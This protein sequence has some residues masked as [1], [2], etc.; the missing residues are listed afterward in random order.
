[1][2]CG[3]EKWNKKSQNTRRHEGFTVSPGISEAWHLLQTLPKKLSLFRSV[4]NFHV[5]LCLQ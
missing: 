3:Y 1:M 5:S 4:Y 2:R